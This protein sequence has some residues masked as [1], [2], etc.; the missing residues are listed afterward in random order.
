[1]QINQ[2]HL[3]STIRK[4]QIVDNGNHWLIRGIPVTVDN[5]LMNGIR[6]PAEENAKGLPTI[7]K[8]PITGGHPKD[9]NGYPISVNDDMPEWYIGSNVVNQY[10]RNSVNYVDVKASKSM[11][12]NSD[13]KLGSYFA[14]KLEKK[15]P[16]GVSTGL[17]LTP[18]T[19]DDG[20][21][22]ATNQQYDHLAFLHDSERPA[23]GRDTMVSFNS[24]T[25]IMVVNVDE[26]CESDDEGS[27]TQKVINYFNNLFGINSEAGYSQRRDLIVSELNKDKGR[28]DMYL[29]PEDVFSEYFIY[30]KDGMTLKQSYLISDGAISFVGEPVRV[31]KE[32]EYKPFGN[33]SNNRYNDNGLTDK[34]KE[35]DTMSDNA[36]LLQAINALHETV[37]AQGE[38]IAS[39]TAENKELKANMDEMKSKAE[40]EA[41]KKAEEEAKKKAMEDEEKKAMANALGLEESE[42]VAMEINTLRKLAGK[43]API[44]GNARG[45]YQHGN[46][47]AAELPSLK[48]Y[49]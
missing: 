36:E 6:Y 1:M 7:N 49:Q 11:M 42:A 30:T 46:S 27:V 40:A 39:V 43:T 33:D 10:N 12:R 22:L 18:I 15:Q 21:T 25:G 23:G 28:D 31:V 17:T 13:N 38:Q 3:N 37:K 26:H 41:K 9:E 34:S 35:G 5:A 29:Y 48:D 45:G 16:F 4:G 24:D 20:E 44:V 19:N 2:I 47:A 32:V 8:K 14:D